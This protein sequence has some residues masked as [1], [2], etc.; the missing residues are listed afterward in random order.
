MHTLKILALLLL[1]CAWPVM[2]QERPALPEN[3]LAQLKD[4][5]RRVLADAALPFDDECSLA[6]DPD[7]LAERLTTDGLQ[8]GRCYLLQCA[9]TADVDISVGVCLL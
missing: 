1:L 2:A 4:E 3:P 5:V 6:C 7:A 8:G 9:L